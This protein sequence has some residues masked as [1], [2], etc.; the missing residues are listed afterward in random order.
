ML[1]ARIVMGRA[2]PMIFSQFQ[3]W[4]DFLLQTYLHQPAPKIRLAF[5]LLKGRC[6]QQQAI[7]ERCAAIQITRLLLT[8]T[9]QLKDIEKL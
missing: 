2:N 3:L 6:G 5:P 9:P 7:S 4:R 8:F 1:R